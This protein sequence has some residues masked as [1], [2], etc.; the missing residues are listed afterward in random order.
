MVSTGYQR[1]SG[2]ARG[3]GGATSRVGP[4]GGLG[5]G[6]SGG[7]AAARCRHTGA[8][9][10]GCG[11][12]GA[13][14]NTLPAWQPGMPARAPHPAPAAQAAAAHLRDRIGGRHGGLQAA[15][16]AEGAPG[17]CECGPA[18][19][20]VPSAARQPDGANRSTLDTTPQV[21]SLA[22][23]PEG[24]VLTGS[25]DKTVKLWRQG[26]DGAYAEELTLVGC[27]GNRPPPPPP[28]A[29]C[30]L[31]PACLRPPAFAHAR[32][33]RAARMT[34]PSPR[35]AGGPHRLCVGAG[36][37]AAR[38]AGRLPGRRRGV[39]R[40]RHGGAR[41]G[42]GG[43]AGARAAP[44]GAP[45][46][47]GQAAGG[48]CSTRCS[49]AVRSGAAAPPAACQSAP[50]RCSQPPP[51]R[52]ASPP[53]RRRARCRPWRWPPTASSPP[54]RWTRRSGCGATASVCRCGR[55]RVAGG[56]AARRAMRAEQAAG[57]QLEV[58]GDAVQR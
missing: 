15:P 30:C 11:R 12:A 29:V 38:H 49:R 4:G 55:R 33:D 20:L 54:P 41:L 21:R 44:G 10:G 13:S 56:R 43:A 1:V 17:G 46:P 34:C 9:A 42:P 14:P 22:I 58:G 18:R 19:P 45:V 35:R 24:A 27:L 26:E 36:L 51:P 3:P 5:R 28:P 53:P 48:A 2:A 31:L 16:R 7:A 23:T 50:N 40:A 57:A 8:I 47:G 32:P 37:R 39:G 52:R 25:R 6:S